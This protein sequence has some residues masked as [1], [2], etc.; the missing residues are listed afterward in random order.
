MENNVGLPR[1][2][3]VP[4]PPDVCFEL[5]VTRGSL[6]KA[7]A[8]MNRR[9]YRTV[10]GNELNL[11][12]VSHA[13]WNY[14]FDHPFSTKKYFDADKI[15]Q[16]KKALTDDQWVKFI[17]IKAAKHFGKRDKR[18][19]QSWIEACGFE[20]YCEIYKRTYPTAYAAHFVS[21]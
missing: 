14:I 21:V 19:F 9:G 17:I 7:A 5:W 4:I 13:A 15:A 18:I 12:S 3:Q 6:T 11:I 8:E 10:N 20:R 2:W 16:K 1:Y